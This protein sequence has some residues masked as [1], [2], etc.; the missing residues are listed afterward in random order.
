MKKIIHKITAILMTFVVVLSTMSFTVDMHFCG[1]TMVDYSILNKAESCG[2]EMDINKNNC[3]TVQ[4]KSCCTD[5]Q[6]VFD[7]QDNLKPSLEKLSLE[8]QQFIFSFV[9]TS[10]NLTEVTRNNTTYEE[11]APPLVSKQLFKLDES[12][13]I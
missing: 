4:N 6:I 8:Q 11:Y 7:G 2:M 9:Y 3:P 10:L 13:L 5:K 12:Y 1:D